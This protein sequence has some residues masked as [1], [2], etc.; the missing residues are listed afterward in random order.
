MGLVS[1][2]PHP[3]EEQ[4]G[5]CGPRGTL[6][7]A[8]HPQADTDG[9]QQ[10]RSGGGCAV[11]GGSGETATGPIAGPVS[12]PQHCPSLPLPSPGSGWGQEPFSSSILPK[13][14]LSCQTPVLPYGLVIVLSP[15]MMP[16]QGSIKL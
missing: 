3:E 15:C 10:K 2:Q 14:R 9:C 5:V 16:T 4:E 8:A 11:T 1:L 13:T 6:D 7:P 12:L